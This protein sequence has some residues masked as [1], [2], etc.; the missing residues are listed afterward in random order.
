[1]KTLAQHI[2]L[3]KHPIGL[4]FVCFLALFACFF[5]VFAQKGGGRKPALKDSAQKLV[6]IPPDSLKKDTLSLAQKD[7]VAKKDRKS[8]ILDSLKTTSDL[9]S[10]VISRAEDSIVFDVEKQIL[11]LYGKAGIDYD[12]LKVTGGKVVVDW[13]TQMIDVVGTPLND[14]LGTVIDMPVFTQGES[15]YTS[16]EM[17]YN[18]KSKKGRVV[19]ARTQEG[20]GYVLSDVVKRNA[21]NSFF[22]QNGKYTTC[23]EPEHPHFYI[24]SRKMKVIPDNKIISGPLNLV[25]EEFPIPIIIP[26]GFF[27]NTKKKE[28]GIVL[29]K[30]G[31]GQDRGYFLQGLGYFWGKNP[32]ATLLLTG[33]IYTLGGWTVGATSNY[34]IR[35]QMTGNISFDYGVARFNEATDPDFQKTTTWRLGWQHQQG[36]NQYTNLSASVSYDKSFNRNLNQ[37]IN[38]ALANNQNSSV[39]FNKSRIGNLPISLNLSANARQDINRKTVS[40]TLP[41]LSVLVGQQ[42][43]FKNIGG[44]SKVFEPLKQL[45]FSYSLNASNN[46]SDMN[47]DLVGLIFQN[48]NKEFVYTTNYNG[49]IDTVRKFGYEY[50][51]TGIR[52]AVPISTKIR[53]FNYV[54]VNSSFNFNE[55][56]YLRTVEKTWNTST[57]S[58]QNNAINGFAAARD[59]S[60]NASANTTFYLFYGLKPSKRNFLVRQVII[61]T[62]GY[63]FH[64]DFSADKYGYYSSYINGQNTKVK[65]SRFEGLGASPSAG[66]SQS[67][68]FGLQSTL[69]AKLR[70]KE[71]FKPDFP[72][73][74]DKFER[75]RL[76]DN[77]GLSGSYNFAADSFKL[78]DISLNA[79]AS[80]FKNKLNINYN[81]S[82]SP[83]RADSLRR[84]KEFLWDTDQKLGRLTSSTLSFSTSFQSP[85]G[86][87]K[88][89][90]KSEG[91]DENEYQNIMRYMDGYVDFNVPWTVSVN[92]NLTYSKPTLQKASLINVLNLN[93]DLNLTPKWKIGFTTGYDFKAKGVSENTNFTV[94]RD[95]HCWELSFGWVPLGRFQQYNLSINVKSSTL[96]DL[97]LNRVRQW[98]NRFRDL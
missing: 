80:V 76:L 28:T 36:I 37:S 31:N 77:M 46:V 86:K 30:Y 66:E 7:S 97:K 16:T 14:S 49:S 51:Q 9:K 21:D 71:S 29:P 2:S 45:G 93:G 82:F 78:S 5:T 88:P 4:R 50:F 59:Y 81:G 94:Y 10:K 19:N 52:H 23:N 98:Q 42:T 89:S 44:K 15:K 32:Y 75:F 67:M 69:E 33:D 58:V 87:K 27:P 6:T 65:Y 53:L 13:K 85:K 84:Y 95:L 72:E 25:I 91:F 22:A 96:Q 26:F 63:N 62:I 74:E 39:S 92:Y 60:F 56:W 8:I 83:Y 20:D 11:Y 48:P 55:Y 54:N 40:F 70:K 68:S 12:D 73:K 61:P 41:E 1:M 18:F 17:S 64:P 79:R 38:Q 57:S 24:R 35:T 34:K 47:Q 43:P 3:K 90:K